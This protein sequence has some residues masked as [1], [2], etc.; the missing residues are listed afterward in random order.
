M[1]WCRR[2]IDEPAEITVFRQNDSLLANGGPDHDGIIHPR[3]RL[4]GCRDIMAFGPQRT[5]NAKVAT[6]V[7][8]KAHSALGPEHDALLVRQGISGI[9]DSR[10]DVIDRE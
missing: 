1:G 2:R 8:Q 4:D 6:F 10:T 5:D 7:R 3:H 9:T